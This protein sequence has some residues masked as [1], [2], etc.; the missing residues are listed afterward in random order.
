[1]RRGRFYVTSIPCRR[2]RDAARMRRVRAALAKEL[3]YRARIAERRRIFNERYPVFPY[4]FYSVPTVTIGPYLTK[5]KREV[6]VPL[7]SRGG[8][9]SKISTLEMR[10]FL[11]HLWMR[12][13]AR[14]YATIISCWECHFSMWS[15]RIS[16]RSI[17]LLRSSRR[18]KRSSIATSMT[19]A[20]SKVSSILSA[21]SG[22]LEKNAYA[23][24]RHVNRRHICDV[25]NVR[26]NNT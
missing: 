14:V 11:H 6:V 16:M 1:M 17:R 25:T 23:L 2:E 5:D 3:R 26:F 9:N 15:R 20:C 8:P 24:L 22:K 18:H 19:C 7:E 10:R 4:Y 13:K 12:N 21:I